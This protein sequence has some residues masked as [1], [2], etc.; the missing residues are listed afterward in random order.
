MSSTG[1]NTSRASRCSCNVHSHGS[2]RKKSAMAICTPILWTTLN[3]NGCK[4]RYQQVIRP[5]VSFMQWSHKNRL[6][7]FL[8]GVSGRQQ[9][10]LSYLHEDAPAR[11]PSGTPNTVPPPI[12]PHTSLYWPWAPPTTVTWA[13]W[14]SA[15]YAWPT[16]VNDNII[17]VGGRIGSMRVQLSV[18]E[19]LEGGQG[20]EL[21][22]W[23]H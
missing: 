2:E 1:L 15:A 22:N 8:Y 18:C 17:Q 13:P 20:T 10:K 9:L 11:N 4:A 12:Q 21:P 19:A 5:L 16:T 23:K 6:T 3:L 7:S 14:P